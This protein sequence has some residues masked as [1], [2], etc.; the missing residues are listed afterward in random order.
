MLRA[1]NVGMYMA[2]IR[3]HAVRLGVRRAWR[4]FCLMRRD[5]I[6]WCSAAAVTVTAGTYDERRVFWVVR[7]YSVMVQPTLYFKSISKRYLLFS[8]SRNTLRVASSEQDLARRAYKHK[9]NDPTHQLVTPALAV[10]DCGRHRERS[11]PL[12]PASARKA[13]A[14]VG[15]SGKRASVCTWRRDDT[16]ALG[17]LRHGWMQR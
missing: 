7:M 12:R 1:C 16:V 10:A 4:A 14:E 6:A 8:Y 15:Q 5:C 3:A 2:C 9:R 11:A 17:G 13:R